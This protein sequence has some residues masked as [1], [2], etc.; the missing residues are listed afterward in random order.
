MFFDMC[1][2]A[3]AVCVTNVI[4]IQ[5]LGRT[6]HSSADLGTMRRQAEL[7]ELADLALSELPEPLQSPFPSSN[8][9][10][11]FSSLRDAIFLPP[12]PIP[13]EVA[14]AMTYPSPSPFSRSR[15]GLCAT[16][17]GDVY[18]TV[19]LL[20]CGGDS[21][22]P[23]LNPAL[24]I[25]GCV[26]ALHGGS[27]DEG[28]VDPSLFLLN[29]VSCKW[30]KIT[31]HGNAPVH[32]YTHS[33]VA[34]DTTI[35]IYGGLRN[36]TWFGIRNSD[37]WAFNFNTLRTKPTWEL[38]KPCSDQRSPHPDKEGILVPYRKG[39]MLIANNFW[40]LT[41]NPPPKM[42]SGNSVSLS[43]IGAFFDFDK[44]EH[45]VQNSSIHPAEQLTEIQKTSQ[46]NLE[47][48]L[49][50]LE[51]ENEKLKHSQV[52][53]A[54]L[55]RE[56]EKFKCRLKDLERENRELK[57]SRGQMITSIIE[58]LSTADLSATLR[59]VD[60]QDVV[61]FLA[62]LIRSQELLQSNTEPRHILR[63][64]RRVVKSAQVFPKH[65]E[66]S[67]VQCDL[68]NPI[69]DE[70]GFG[71]IYKGTFREQSVCVKAVRIYETSPKARKVSRAQA[72]ELALLAHVSHPNVIRLYGAYLSNESKPRI[73]IVSPWME[74]GDLEGYLKKYPNTPR[75]PLMSD[76][77]AGL[78]FLHNMGIVHAD[79]KARNVLVSQ[80]QRAM[81]AD[82]GVSTIISTNVGTTTAEDFSGTVYWM[83]P[84]LL[85]AE[86]GQ[87]PTPQSD[88]WGFGCICFEA[89]TGE[90]PF[91]VHYRP[92]QLLVAFMKGQPTPLRP[93]PDC[94][95]TIVDGG[96]LVVLAER[97]W[98][99]DLSQRPTAAE[100]L[101]FLVKLNVMDE[102]PSMDEELVSFEV[103]KAGREE[104]KIDYGRI[105]S[106]VRKVGLNYSGILSVGIQQ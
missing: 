42:R 100:A 39:L 33:M 69:N 11:T 22:G 86:T 49:S 29:L 27:R 55:Q 81:L 66:V 34:V 51:R 60:A 1:G 91:I 2:F 78:D 70:G 74:H 30:S 88:M 80:S 37:M 106:L 87:P 12:S 18:N 3:R 31:A 16:K 101:E 44:K 40:F 47:E 97:C 54:E 7:A 103:A 53:L 28:D 75:I 38:V 95:P 77:A 99:Y 85:L 104:V 32:L 19:T 52:I 20:Q 92:H 64:L 59:G 58:S 96:P 102:R 56:N 98:N 6:S 15:L 76:V 23:R 8:I 79:L 67:D 68:V 46:V 9:P 50:Q 63:V 65:A 4:Y 10:P 84:E 57:L 26:L 94:E 93:K 43:L 71:L 90:V 83:A 21:P 25:V 105:L 72:G 48:K 89:L 41:A 73:C 17:S 61:D 62:E 5:P 13:G 45:V 14:P 36:M 35:Y 24:T 82:F